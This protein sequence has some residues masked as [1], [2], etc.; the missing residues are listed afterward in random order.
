MGIYDR[1]YY[2]ENVR[3]T[4]A[5]PWPTS[6]VG[7]LIALNVAIFLVDA[8][9]MPETSG[10]GHW[11]SDHLAVHVAGRNVDAPDHPFAATERSED[12]LTQPWLW[13]QF[14][15]NGF[16]HSP[17]SLD[18]ILFNMLGLWFLG[19]PVENRY[20]RRE[21]LR[22]YL[23]MII[24]GA[25]AWAV[26]TKLQGRPLPSQC[27]GASGAVAGVVILFALNFPQQQLLLFFVIPVRA[28]V[29]GVALV[30]YNIY[31]SLGG[32]QGSNIAYVGH[33]GGAALALTYYQ[34]D[35]N[36][37]RLFAWNFSWLRLPLRRPRLRVHYPLPEDDSADPADAAAPSEHDL[38]AEVDRI[39]EKI[40]REGE[41]SLTRKERQTLEEASR[42]YQRRRQV[43]RSGRDHGH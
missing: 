31:G 19:P 22:L 30:A 40:S 18:H 16:A 34:F 35:W 41:A 43:H 1:D 6:M 24:A 38:S 37:G 39:L 25:V 17:K 33:L 15:T 4:A 23:A 29:A 5:F 14:V 27:Y 21:F 28:W 42:Q 36:F 32:V 10:E 12:T 8:L 9:M 7:L 11:L 3:R 20:G 13:W 26:V 2:R